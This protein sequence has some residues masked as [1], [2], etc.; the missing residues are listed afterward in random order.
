MKWI[1]QKNL[2]WKV[3]LLKRE[4]YLHQIELKLSANGHGES[5]RANWTKWAFENK[6]YLYNGEEVCCNMS[7]KQ[8]FQEYFVDSLHGVNPLLLSFQPLSPNPLHPWKMFLRRQVMKDFQITDFELVDEF[9][10]K[11]WL[12]KMY[13]LTHIPDACQWEQVE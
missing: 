12:F 8:I 13:T 6:L 5:S 1:H 3:L 10:V 2:D 4:S 9:T 11:K 7:W